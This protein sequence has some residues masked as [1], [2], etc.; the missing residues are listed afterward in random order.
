[1]ELM[2]V[3]RDAKGELRRLEAFAFPGFPA[4]GPKLRADDRTQ[5]IAEQQPGTRGIRK[6]LV[7]EEGVERSARSVNLQVTDYRGGNRLAQLLAHQR[8]RSAAA[9]QPGDVAVSDTAVALK[10]RRTGNYLSPDKQ[11]D[12]PAFLVD[13]IP[14]V[15]L[16]MRA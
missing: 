1:M 6:V 16:R 9:P 13:I 10:R 12:A 11:T 5:Q 2:N 15:H 3:Q 8:H 7:A 4:P 14:I